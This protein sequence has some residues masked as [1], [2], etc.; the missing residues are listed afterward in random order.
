M[1]HL[2]A[3]PWALYLLAA[4]P[5]LA[6]LNVLR[7]R[8]RKLALARVGNLLTL[9]A[10][11]AVRRGPR[12]VRGLCLLLGLIALVLGVAGPQW[13]RDWTQSAAPGRDL[14]VVLD[15]SRSMFA[16]S[17]NRLQRAQTALL[18]LADALQKRGGHRVGLV[19]FAGRARLACPLT[20][21]YDHF[22]D[23]VK[24]V[25]T[26]HSD[27][28][29]GPGEHEASGTRIGL[30]LHHAVAAHNPRFH[31]AQD[32][33]LLSDGDDPARDGEWRYGA[34]EAR[35]Q[36]IPVHTVGIG[37]PNRASSIP[38]TD[39]PLR[40]GDD[41]VRTRLEEAPLRE[42]AEMTHGTYTPAQTRVL[43]LGTAYFDLMAASAL[44]EESEDALPVYQP[45][46]LWFLG[47][48]FGLLTL[49]LVIPD[50]IGLSRRPRWLLASWGPP[51]SL[52]PVHLPPDALLLED[53][54]ES[55]ASDD[56]LEEPTSSADLTEKL[57]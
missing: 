57:E 52:P 3:Q 10:L 24:E 54:P 50:C 48:A 21:D 1:R 15:C 46:Y 13:G 11:L 44:R 29:L 35:E 34:A 32:I 8:A 25:D 30:A 20:H 36:S 26:A 16:E 4:L 55:L 47:P 9:E 38:G 49:A 42:I 37:N 45:R 2:F 14:V 17:P 43:H 7:R 18:D 56:E 6:A 19:V 33:V 31:G 41:E 28:E 5:L 22:R 27:P 12:A 23:L 39:G 53:G 40:H 51:V